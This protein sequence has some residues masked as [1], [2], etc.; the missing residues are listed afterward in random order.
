MFLDSSFFFMVI[1]STL[2]ILDITQRKEWKMTKTIIWHITSGKEFPIQLWKN[3]KVTIELHNVPLDEWEKINLSRDEINIIFLHLTPTEWQSNQR[4]MIRGLETHPQVQ[5]IFVCPAE[6]GLPEEPNR[7]F[8]VLETPLHKLELKWLIDKAIQA[9]LYKRISLDISTSCLS[10]IGFFEGLFEL[11]RKENQDRSEAVRAFEKILSY[12]QEIKKSQDR[13]NHA[14]D[15][16]NE[17]RDKE[18][19][20]LHERIKATEKLEDFRREE[21]KTA[22]E[23]KQ[24]TE[25]VLEYSMIEERGMDRIIK[26]QDKLF[27]YT[28]QEIKDLLEENRELKKRLGIPV[29]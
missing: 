23:I 12:E 5:A 11:A 21:L 25:Q 8:L 15:S 4:L 20:E 6:A 7:S 9:E 19:L 29:E 22:L 18:L 1:F 28:E 16:V 2:Q 27:E 10:N 13:L 26:A 17:L 14:I 3:P 24:A